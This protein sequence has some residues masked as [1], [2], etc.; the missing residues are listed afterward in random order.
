MFVYDLVERKHGHLI[1]KSESVLLFVAI[2]DPRKA[3]EETL[4]E[5]A[6]IGDSVAVTDLLDKGLNVNCKH[7]M[8]GW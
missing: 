3:D 5:A 4:R 2:M 8:N 6:C 1:I 7:A